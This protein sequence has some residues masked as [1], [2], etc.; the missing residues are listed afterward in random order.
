MVFIGVSKRFCTVDGRQYDDIGAFWDQMAA[1][2]GRCK[3]RGL[4]WNWHNNGFDYAIGLCSNEPIIVPDGFSRCEIQLP[5]TGWQHTCG[6]TD[7]L[8]EVYCRIYLAGALTFEIERFDDA[9][10]CRISYWRK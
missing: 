7:A 4:G 1:L 2:Y 8:D 10:N 6:R 5:D 9:G 3:L